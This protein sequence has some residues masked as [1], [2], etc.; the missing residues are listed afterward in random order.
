MMSV[1]LIS[2]RVRCCT[3]RRA[4]VRFIFRPATEEWPFAVVLKAHLVLAA[5]ILSDEGLTTTFRTFMRLVGLLAAVLGIYMCSQAHFPRVAFVAPVH[6]T[7]EWFVFAG[8][9]WGGRIVS[10]PFD[11]TPDGLSGSLGTCG[12]C[13]AG[14]DAWYQE[15]TLQPLQLGFGT[16]QVK[17]EKTWKSEQRGVRPEGLCERFIDG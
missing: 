4:Y 9:G 5:V 17:N 8:R 15:T 12:H 6:L 2:C 14:S 11:K 16:K 3:R 10:F 13:F 1:Q 7:T